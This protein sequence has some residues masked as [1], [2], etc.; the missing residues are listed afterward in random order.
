M[1]SPAGAD[2]IPLTET[3]LPEGLS[4]MARRLSH[5]LRELTPTRVADSLRAWSHK[6]TPP[7]IAG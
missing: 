5:A 6:F 2:K 7:R 4:N 1:S 3:C